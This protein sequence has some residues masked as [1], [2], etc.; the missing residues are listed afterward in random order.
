MIFK[1]FIALASILF[2]FCSFH[3]C[4]CAF[5][6]FFPSRQTHSAVFKNWLHHR[7]LK[8]Q[9]LFASDL[10]FSVLLGSWLLCYWITKT[11]RWWIPGCS[12]LFPPGKYN[13]EMWFP[14]SEANVACL[15]WVFKGKLQSFQREITKQFWDFSCLHCHF[16][17]CS[18][19]I[20]HG[21]SNFISDISPHGI[22]VLQREML[23]DL[24]H[25]P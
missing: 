1:V 15:C 25:V 3:S 4:H 9:W 8:Y 22:K 13:A 16:K 5:G 2:Q 6:V 21:C 14:F 20:Q 12:W 11:G 24:E 18:M 17:N 10:L 7:S 19:G 23:F